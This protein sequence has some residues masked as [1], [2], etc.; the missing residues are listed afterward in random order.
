MD[1][2]RKMKNDI[3]WKHFH[4]KTCGFPFP[5]RVFEF[6]IIPVFYSKLQASGYCY[7]NKNLTSEFRKKY[8]LIDEK[9]D[10]ILLLAGACVM[11]KIVYENEFRA[12]LEA[13]LKRIMPGKKHV[14]M[15]LF[16]SV[17]SFRSFF[18][19]GLDIIYH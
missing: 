18:D 16:M 12:F 10:A 7:K 4:G 1:H 15:I 8:H 2:A 17:S 3:P 14:V 19:L 11:K 6:R 13:K 5:T 9:L